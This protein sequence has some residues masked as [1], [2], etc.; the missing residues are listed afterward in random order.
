MDELF[1]RI[2]FSSAELNVARAPLETGNLRQ[3]LTYI[4]EAAL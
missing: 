2:T 1:C 3:E 4:V